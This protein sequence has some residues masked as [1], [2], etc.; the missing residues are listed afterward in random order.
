MDDRVIRWRRHE[1]AANR[2]AVAEAGAAPGLAHVVR[3][4]SHFEEHV[5]S[6]TTRRELPGTQGVLIIN[7]GETIGLT[8]GDGQTIRLE[9]G[10]G[11]VGGVHTQSAL[12]RTER[13]LQRGIHV[14]LPLASLRRLFAPDMQEIAD[15]VVT[16]D[17]IVGARMAAIGPALVERD[18]GDCFDV[19]EAWLAR[20]LAEAPAPDREVNWAIGRLNADPGV[21]ID[22]LARDIGWSR[23]HFGH[24]FR[25]ATGVTPRAYGRLRRF[26]RL[27]HSLTYGTRPH[28]AD[29]AAAHGFADQPHLA[30][31]IRDISGLTPTMLLQRLLPAGGGVLEG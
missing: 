19:L 15:R 10:E 30:R 12:S 2:W 14:Y 7:F 29:L 24:R 5:T 1:D 6:F 21:R 3:G 26:E 9:A 28:W 4:F 13:G 17:A 16:L 11:F 22:A 25:A 27:M 20:H 8:G 31:E 18:P 23:K